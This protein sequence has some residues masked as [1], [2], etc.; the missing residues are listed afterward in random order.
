[1][2][3]SISTSKMIYN[4]INNLD[5]KVLDAVTSS[6][7]VEDI[8]YLSECN[9]AKEYLEKRL[10]EAFKGEKSIDPKKYEETYKNILETFKNLKFDDKVSGTQKTIEALYERAFSSKDIN[11]PTS[12]DVGSGVNRK[13]EVIIEGS[14]G[15]GKAQNT[16]SLPLLP[17]GIMSNSKHLDMNS[18]TMVSQQS[19]R[20]QYNIINQDNNN[21]VP[22]HSFGIFGQVTKNTFFPKS[23]TTVT[24]SE[25][26]RLYD[27][28]ET[29]P[30]GINSVSNNVLVQSTTMLGLQ[31]TIHDKL[32]GGNYSA[33]AE[34]S[35]GSVTNKSERTVTGVH[36]VYQLPQ[37]F[38]AMLDKSKLGS[39]APTETKE[40]AYD[41]RIKAGYNPVVKQVGHS[42]VSLGVLGE[43]TIASDV[44]QGFALGVRGEAKGIFGK[45]DKFGI[46]ITTAH[47]VIG[48]DLY[49]DNN[50]KT[51]LFGNAQI[52]A[53]YS[54]NF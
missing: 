17:I 26:S 14:N 37:K 5:I 48:S 33:T 50:S 23:T 22:N 43:G 54:V 4:F 20:L 25:P 16:F 49:S 18:Q 52:K 13:N 42:L 24:I 35:V 7:S 47:G 51:K 27:K 10:K 11:Y 1:M 9:K 15:F 6:G 21:D 19:L 31:G 3:G 29:F 44:K 34:L 30:V 28:P 36:G 39:L 53:G 38:E 45:E 32:R 8:N 41:L 40:A 12:Q 2:T 46:Q